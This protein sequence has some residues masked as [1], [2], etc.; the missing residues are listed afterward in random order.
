MGGDIWCSNLGLGRGEAFLSFMSAPISKPRGPALV[1]SHINATFLL[2]CWLQIQP[3]V[4]L[5]FFMRM[6]TFHSHEDHRHSEVEKTVNPL[7]V[8]SVSQ[9]QGKWE[10]MERA[11]DTEG[12]KTDVFINLLCF[13]RDASKTRGHLFTALDIDK[14]QW[15]QS[16]S[17]CN[18]PHSPPGFVG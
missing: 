16:D 2:L 13:P 7:Q 1:G 15:L 18:R 9:V 4:W 10:F 14:D 6:V 8:S 12:I 3:Y 11:T 5:V 17:L